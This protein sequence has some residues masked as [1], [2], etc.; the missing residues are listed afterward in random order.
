MMDNVVVCDIVEEE[1]ALP[2]KKVP[3]DGCSRSAL[4]VPFFAT[5]V[6]QRRIGVVEVSDHDDYR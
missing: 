1:T 2:S 4:K 6:G 3:V 5:V